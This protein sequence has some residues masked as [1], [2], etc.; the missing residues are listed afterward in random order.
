VHIGESFVGSGADAAHVN[1]VLGS[2]DGPVGTAWATA[3]ATPSAG[4]QPFLVV[5]EPGVAVRPHTLFVSKATLSTDAHSRITWGAAQAG[6][7]AGVADAVADGT[8][9]TPADDV[10]IAAVW[11]D[12]AA[13]DDEAVFENNRRSTHDAL[14]AAMSDEPSPDAAVTRRDAAWNPFFRSGSSTPDEG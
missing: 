2:R 1:V 14:V 8:L 3:L 4:H 7:A 5:I 6:V 9:T 12:P 11:V 10:L 13:S